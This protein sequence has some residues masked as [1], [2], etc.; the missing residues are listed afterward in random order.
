MFCRNKGVT[1]L[2]KNSL[3]SLLNVATEKPTFFNLKIEISRYFNDKIFCA[4]TVVNFQNLLTMGSLIPTSKAVCL[5]IFFIFPLHYF[6]LSS[7]RIRAEVT[8]NRIKSICEIRTE[9]E[10]RDHLDSF[11]GLQSI[12]VK[13]PCFRQDLFY[14]GQLLQWVAYT[15]L[16]EAVRDSVGELLMLPF[17][18]YSS[19]LQD[20]VL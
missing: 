11:S 8:E 6:V 10:G 16:P 12:V 5:L 18:F 13:L 1:T 2:P 4:H 9:T 15:R 7:L 14:I 19:L 3:M 17:P 20:R